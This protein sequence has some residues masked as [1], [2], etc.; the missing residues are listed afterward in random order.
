MTEKIC[1]VGLGYVG[2]PVAAKFAEAGYNVVGIDVDRKKIEKINQGVFPLKGEEPGM[3]ELVEGVVK[4]GKLKAS[5]DYDECKD[6][7]F[8]LVSVQTPMKGDVPDYSFLK[9]AVEEVGKRLKKGCLI[10]IESTLAPKTMV[11]IVKSVLEKESGMKAGEDFYLVHCPERVR[12]GHLLYQLENFNRVIGAINKESGEKAKE[13][14]SKIVK[15]NLDVTDMTSAELVKTI[16]NTYRDVQIAFAN[17][18]A[19]ICEKL[20]ADVYDVRK[21]VNKCPW[22]DMYTPGAGVGGHCI[23]KDSRL[24]AHSVSGVYEPTFIREA[25]RINNYM[26]HHV[27]DLVKEN[28]KEKNPK[29]SILGMAFVKDT[30]DTRNSPSLVIIEELKKGLFEVEAYDPYAEGYSDFESCLKNSDCL[31]LATD[32]AEFRKLNTSGELEK[33]KKLMRTPLIVDGRNLFDKKLC[34]EMGFV[35]KG[36]GKG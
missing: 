24:L 35:Y 5:L 20:G 11:N 6:A 29:V 30:E 17:E 34:E 22:R 18:M 19:L 36:I 9:G 28:L 32:H 2:I 8:I 31:V 15:G 16:E 27:V 26:P 33:I 4:E 25:R 21:L 14:Y 3:K 12:P 7:D 13:F 23:P 1:V 10:S